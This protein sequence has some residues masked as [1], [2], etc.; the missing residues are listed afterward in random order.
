MAEDAQPGGAL[1]GMG[2]PNPGAGL[3]SAGDGKDSPLKKVAC[4]LFLVYRRSQLCV[5]VSSVRERPPSLHVPLLSVFIALCVAPLSSVSQQRLAALLLVLKLAG[6]H[7]LE[8]LTWCHQR[9]TV[10]ACVLKLLQKSTEARVLWVCLRLVRRWALADLPMH[11]ASRV[12][13]AGSV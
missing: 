12:S 2:T 9:T 1:A 3:S 10:F 5:R 7:V 13:F 4:C 11:P 8:P 6:S